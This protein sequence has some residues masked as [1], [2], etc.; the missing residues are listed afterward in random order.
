MKVNSFDIGRLIDL[1]AQCTPAQ[2]VAIRDGMFQIVPKSVI[3]KLVDKWKAED[4]HAHAGS[5]R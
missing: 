4:D 1:Q 2:K 3:D 5:S